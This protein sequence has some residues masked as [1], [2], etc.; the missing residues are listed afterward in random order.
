MQLIDPVRKFCIKCV[1]DILYTLPGGAAE[2]LPAVVVTPPPGGK[3]KEKDCI[4]VGLLWG[5]ID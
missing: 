1:C 3:I 4:I 2:D 5:K